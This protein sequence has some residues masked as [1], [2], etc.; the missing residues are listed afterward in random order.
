M[1]AR[2]HVTSVVVDDQDD[3]FAFYTNRLGFIPKTDVCPS[4]S[5]ASE[6]FNPRPRWATSSR[7]SSA[8]PRGN[9]IQMIGR[10]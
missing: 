6:S 7:R 5:T 3:A 1:H 4:N 9:L 2:L 8:T 10:A